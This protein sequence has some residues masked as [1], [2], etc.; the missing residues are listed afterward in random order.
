M[1]TQL[2]FAKSVAAKGQPRRVFDWDKAAA[3][4]KE[5]N[6]DCAYAGLSSDMEYTSGV[7]WRDGKPVTDE[8][9]YLS[10]NWAI[11]VLSIDGEEEECWSY[12]EDTPGWHSQTKWPQSALDIVN[13]H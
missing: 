8:Y 6:P 3:I 12:A 4:L 11:P 13:G 9:T 10:S 2:A 1:N 7:I 5:C